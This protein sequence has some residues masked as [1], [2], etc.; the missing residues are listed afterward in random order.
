MITLALEMPID[1]DETTDQ[2]NK[3]NPDIS[4]DLIAQM[5]S[6]DPIAFKQCVRLYS[7]RV[8]SIAYRIVGNADEA[9]DIAQEVFVRIYRSIDQYDSR[10]PF[11]GWVYRVAVNLAIDHHRREG[12]H[13]KF[14]STNRQTEQMPG[15]D[16]A[17]PDV[18]TERRELVGTIEQLT[19]GLSPSQ[20]KVFVLRDLQGFSSSEISTILECSV[21]TV[22]VHLSNARQ[23]IKT[24]LLEIYP[25][26]NGDYTI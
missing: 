26:L 8:Y 7:P 16:S 17:R 4:E 2:M 14:S 3:T 19:G 21:S 22:R 6:G 15:D 9:Q 10:Y 5:R 24:A 20:Q 18:D 13:R 23:K 25:D 12:R 11:S 1:G